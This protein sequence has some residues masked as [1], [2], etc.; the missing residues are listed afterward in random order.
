MTNLSI[1]PLL[2]AGLSIIPV[3]PQTKRPLGEWKPYQSRQATSYEVDAWL[4]NGLQSMAVICGAVSGNLEILDFDDN[5]DAAYSA[6]DF[7][8]PWRDQV[9][10][11]IDRYGL[12]YWRTGGGGY[13]VGYRC[14]QVEGNLKLAWVPDDTQQHGRSI[15]IETR[16][17]G[18]YAVIPPSLH[19]SGRRYEMMAG[20]LTAIPTIPVAVRDELLRAARTL[21]LMRYT[22]AER[23]A[24]RKEAHAGERPS[25]I[26]AYNERYRIA[27]MLATHGYTEGH[28][29]RYSRPGQPDSMGVVVLPNDN[30]SFHWSSND[31]LNRVNGSGRPLP[32]DPFNVFCELEHGGDM[33]AAAKAAATLLGMSQ[34]K[35]SQPKDSQAETPEAGQDRQDGRKKQADILAELVL[36]QAELFTGDDGQGYA[37]VKKSDHTEVLRLSSGGFADWLT[38]IYYAET[39]SIPGNQAKADARGL[40]SYMASQ[41]TEPIFVR[42]GHHQG[43]LY[44]DLGT[45]AWDAIEIDAAGWRVVAK[46]PVNFVR[47]KAMLPLPRPER[48]EDTT[49]LRPFLNIDDEDWPLVEAWQLSHLYAIGPKPVLAYQ[50]QAGSGKSTNTRVHK[51]VFDPNVADLRGRFT[52]ERDLFVAAAGAWVMAFDNLSHLSHDQSDALCRLATGGAFTKRALHTDGDEQIFTAIRPVIISGIGDVLD[53]QDLV[54]RSIIIATPVLPESKRKPE[55]QF[56]GEF[57]Q[58]H[59]RILGAFLNAAAVALRNLATTTLPKTPR[60]ADFALFSAAAAPALSKGGR[61]FI[62]AYLENR[63]MAAETIVE[64]SLLADVIKRW[65]TTETIWSNTPSKLMEKLNQV[66]TDK[67]REDRSWPKSPAKLKGPLERLAPALR[68]QSIDIQF[69]YSNGVRTWTIK[70]IQGLQ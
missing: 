3:S 31:P 68:S 20:D 44:L 45:P 40:F 48:W 52:E 49:I 56:W 34:A 59:P 67:E 50:S 24:V 66:A 28:R 13:Q 65:F 22:K 33:K 19:P 8:F 7:W 42:T 53:R 55:A 4:E 62:D 64:S 57:E 5:S 39:K 51:R 10:P 37:R 26:N 17:E 2:N 23:E 1:W 41:R 43:R 69:K 15:A 18:G 35:A 6:N 46:P 38:Q 32:V 14:E 11:I 47:T 60:M 29:G 30:I 27:E 58:A 54:D 12:P 63:E 16:G 36:A 25:V 70:R 21:D 61:N 9:Q